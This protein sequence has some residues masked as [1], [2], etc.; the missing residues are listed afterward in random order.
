MI[1]TMQAA[2]IKKDLRSVIANKNTLIPILIVPLIFTVLLPTMFILLTHF[3]PEENGD[4]QAML[5]LLPIGELSGDAV[6]DITALFLN[7]IM[8]VFFMIIPIM[9]ASVMAA[10]SFVGEKEKRTL[11]TLLYC[12]LS[13]KQIF[14]AKIFASFSLSMLVS[15]ASF[16]TMLVVSQAE[17][18]I[19]SGHLLLPDII[20]LITMLLVSP[21]LALIAI[22]I[23]V[24]GS[25]KAKTMEESQQRSVFLILPMLFLIVGQFTG[26]L[27]I[28]ALAL[29]GFGAVFAIV[30]LVCIRAAVRNLNCE[31]LSI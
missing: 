4:F 5:D 1:N 23:I 13:L 22:T 7:R 26:L 8:P 18:L 16:L 20:W 27:L 29:L 14:R 31:T 24:R 6:R 11:E 10:S 3:L 19:I 2:L 9:S 30:A 28:N 15:A 25:A 17:I 12:P 21:S